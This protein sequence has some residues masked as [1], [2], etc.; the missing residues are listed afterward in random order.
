MN[1]ILIHI[2]HSSYFIPNKYKHLFWLK[3]D[4]LFQEQ[5]KMT[6]SFT[7]ELFNI[8]EIYKLIFPVSRLVCD[9]ERFRNE[10]DEEMTKQGMWVCYTKTS[11]LKP[12]KAVNNKHKQE[13]LKLYYDKHHKNF[14]ILVEES[15]KDND[16]CLI[17]DAHSFPSVSLP[18]ELHSQGSRPDICIGT[19]SFH[20]PQKIA[21]YLYEAFSDLGYNVGINNPFCGTIVPLKFYGKEKKV[22]SIMLEINRSLYM[23]EKIG[24]K[25]NNF[26]RIKKDIEKIILLCPFLTLP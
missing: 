12:L 16:S 18:Y 2:P 10:K 19:D 22:H 9:V 3:E 15:L 17:I 4:E 11:D 23:D 7:N 14:E 1:N 20:T 13:I 5:I 25:N 6:D 21:D 26:Q 24:Q 8:K